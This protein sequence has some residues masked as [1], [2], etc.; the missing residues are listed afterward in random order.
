MEAHRV[1][2]ALLCVSIWSFAAEPI[3][4]IPS[5]T[6]LK[7]DADTADWAG[8]GLRVDAMGILQ[9]AAVD[10]ANFDPRFRLAWNAEGL[11]LL[12]IVRDDLLAEEANDNALFMGDG[13]EIFVGER[14]GG[15]MY[16]QIALAPGVDSV[17]KALRISYYDHRRSDS[18]A[19]LTSQQASRAITG[20]YVVEILMPWSNLGMKQAPAIG[21][22]LGFQLYIADRDAGSSRTGIWYPAAATHERPENMH[23]VRLSAQPSAP[24]AAAA[25]AR[26]DGLFRTVFDIT[27]DTRHKAGTT[28]VVSSRG[29]EIGRS[30]LQVI[31]GRPL[32]RVA[33]P[34][35]QAG[36]SYDSLTISLGKD[37][38]APPVLQ[39]AG[40]VAGALLLEQTLSGQFVFPGDA[41]PQLD[42][43]NP[44]LIR[45]CIGAYT[46]KT[47]YYNA[48]FTLATAAS[49]PGRYGAVVQIIPEKGRTLTRYATLY[50]APG[51]WT[52]WEAPVDSA[53]CVF[54]TVLGVGRKVPKRFA[55][56][57]SELGKSTLGQSLGRDHGWAALLA[58]IHE[59]AGSDSVWS[60]ND[61]AALDRQWWVTLKRR[62][63]GNEKRFGSAIV[64]PT[65]LDTAAR[66]LK[67][68][69]AKDAGMQPAA[70]KSIDSLLG[71][72]AK[73]S[74]EGFAVTLA[75]KGVIYLEKGY[76][77]LS[78]RPATAQVP[79]W[80]ASISKF[81]SATMMM[82]LVDRGLVSLDDPVDKF[83]PE[84]AGIKVARPLTVRHL[85]T[86]TGGM[87]G[88]WGDEL[89]DF[90]QLIA[91][92]YPNLAVNKR[93]EYNGAGNSLGSKI[94]ETISGEAFPQFA[95]NH[96]F[97]PLGNENSQMRG[98]SADARC[99]ASDMARF[100][101]MMLNGG[102]YG[103]WRFMS[104]ASVE[105]MMPV[106]VQPLVEGPTSTY[107]G[108]GVMPMTDAGLSDK[109]FGH[110]A[111]SSATLIIDPVLEM[112]IVMNR[113]I[114]G[115]R[116]YE[117]RDAFIK[118][119]T[120]GVAK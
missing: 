67:K 85:Y 119:I 3:F 47:T 75:R 37:K 18:L 58:A 89:H 97:H 107:W 29:K 27:A 102:A 36:T 76:G 120:E 4:D 30:T 48:D 101:Q 42:F 28:V 65:K 105:R 35:P 114:G 77:T 74:G 15:P 46:V 92:Y 108:I 62:L 49:K 91:D 6:G 57:L 79:S 9:D 83:L 10:P 51:F 19:T 20:G 72:W 21:R 81:M 84:F 7:A 61:A 78:D 56:Q 44:Y 39:P 86:H 26:Y 66:V 71:V 69:T 116:F 13:H 104:P 45:Q 118:L 80:M 90:E 16:Y 54:D 22:E 99:S 12:T 38:I 32:A 2:I 59:K 50:R 40:T 110:G 17:H 25:I 24:V 111:A 63:N 109:A 55:G 14:K 88:H 52:E 82:M 93:H 87:W 103:Q 68:G 34:F 23:R 117:F 41:F 115:P 43:A 106:S 64:G 112:V 31:S 8:N 11:W 1:L 33:L 5:V 113:N 100:A 94:I 60:W 96:L 53:S 70:V 98:S 73:Q 95:Y